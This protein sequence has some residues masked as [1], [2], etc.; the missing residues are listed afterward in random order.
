[1]SGIARNIAGWSSW[2]L[3]RLIILRSEVRILFPQLSI[4]RGRYLG[5]WRGHKI[6]LGC[7]ET[8]SN[9]FVYRQLNESSFGC[10]FESYFGKFGLRGCLVW[11]TLCH[12]VQSG[13]FESLWDRQN[14]LFFLKC[15]FSSAGQ[16]ATYVERCETRNESCTGIISLIISRRLLNSI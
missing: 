14:N 1:M 12:S 11:P 2:Q 4:D 16:S 13:G 7:L 10:R 8:L 15:P 6:F 9:Y 3:V 5:I